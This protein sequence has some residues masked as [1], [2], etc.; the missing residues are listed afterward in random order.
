[1][2]GNELFDFIKRVWPYNRSL[3]GEGNRL[4]L[5]AIADIEPNLQTIRYPS[6]MKCF[7]WEI[8]LEWNVRS[9]YILD[10]NGKN[11]VD[12][13]NN[14][15]HLVSYSTPVDGIL[16]LESLND[17]LYSLPEQPTLIPYRT[18]YYRE[19]WGFCITDT[20]RRSLIPG[21]YYVHIDSTLE[22]GFLEIGEIYIE[23]QTKSEIV[24]TTYICHPSMANNEL[25]GPAIA[26][27]LANFLRNQNNHYSYR[28]IFSPETI[29]SISYLATNFDRMKRNVIAGYV[30]TCLGDENN[31][32]FLPSRTGNTISDKLALRVLKEN[33]INFEQYS[34][35]DR[36]SDERQYCSP[37]IDLPFCSVMRSK[38]GTY[39]SYHTS[40]DNLDFISPTGLKQSLDFYIALVR[41]FEKNRVPKTTVYGEP[42]FSKRFLR[43]TLGGNTILTSRSRALSNIVALSDGTFDFTELA[44]AL[45]LP[46]EE[47]I[48]CCNV[49]LKH[50]LINLL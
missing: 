35:L 42:M 5:T 2:S 22:P 38:Y 30:L 21:N 16:P 40:G 44:A 26:I 48:E 47:L 8:P 41:S 10:P 49:L 33:S 17:H 45:N 18:S 50:D 24:F 46:L 31:W 19:D 43:E 29:G 6:G 20:I 36:G 15:L 34:F 27:G 37:L 3:T 1:M 7:D 14:N 11:I 23:G 39:P 12:F 13:Q 25:S 28:I 4:T 9:A 32:S